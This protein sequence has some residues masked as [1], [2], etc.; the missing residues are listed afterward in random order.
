M[1]RNKESLLEEIKF[2]IQINGKTR[3]IINVSKD[4]T[5]D[6]IEKFVKEHSKAKK[7]L[8]IRKFLK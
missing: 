5:Q 1:A 2:A 7:F 3:D 8:K 6:K 4:S